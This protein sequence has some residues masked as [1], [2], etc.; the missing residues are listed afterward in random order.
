L[1]PLSLKEKRA[2]VNEQIKSFLKFLSER[3]EIM[4]TFEDVIKTYQLGLCTRS[5]LV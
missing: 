3:M 1:E 2:V 4:A 5:S